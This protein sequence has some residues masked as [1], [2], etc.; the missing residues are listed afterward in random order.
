MAL[1]ARPSGAD[2][3]PLFGELDPGE[4]GA[5]IET[6]A[7][8]DS[9][10]LEF[11]ADL[12]TRSGL[13]YGCRQ[14]TVHVRPHGV[15]MDCD[16]TGGTSGSDMVTFYLQ[17]EVAGGWRVSGGVAVDPPP[18]EASNGMWDPVDVVERHFTT[19][20]EA[21]QGLRQALGELRGVADCRPPTPA[22]WRAAALEQTDW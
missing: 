1:R 14:L 6:V 8:I 12:A 11:R 17:L 4:Y 18:H 21:M 5:V 20:T 19:P 10:L 3:T 16:V 13:P 15:T 22:A 7:A 2:L 9:E